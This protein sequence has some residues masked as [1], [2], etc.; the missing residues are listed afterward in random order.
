MSNLKRRYLLVGIGLGLLILIIAIALKSPPKQSTNQNKRT[1]V[2]VMTLEEQHVAPIITGYGRVAPKHVWQA[3]AEV[4]GRLIFRHPQLET[5]RLLP[6]GT[7]LLAID[8]LEY[9]L[10]LAQ[11][12]ANFNATQAKLTQL[13][14]QQQN[15]NTSLEIE[16]QRKVLSEQE[17]ARKKTLK[18]KNLVSS[19]EL[20]SQKL[21]LLAQ[22]KQVEELQNSLKLLPDDRKVTQAQLSVDQAKLEDAE[23]RLQKTEIVLPFDARIAEINI[24][25][26]QVVNMSAVMLTAYELGT[27]EIK[28]E[29]AIH[30]MRALANSLHQMP[31]NQRLPSIEKL[32]L[33]AEI[34]F[35]AGDEEF[36]W[37]AKVTRVAETVNPNN[38][39][40]GL[41]LEVE[42]DFH[43]IDLLRR[44]PLTKG[45]FVTAHIHGQPSKHLVVSEK[46]IHQNMLY[47]V[48]KDNRLKKHSLK[49]LFRTPKHV[50]IETN[51]T[52]GDRIV[53]N[54][55][56]PAIDG[57]AL[58][59][60]QAPD[61]NDSQQG[62]A[63]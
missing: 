35:E 48:T 6:Q 39:T 37:P 18:N 55:I 22:T 2:E 52:A 42:Q 30:D 29:V 53:V 7:R 17:Y 60:I 54:D 27:A 46:V 59:I 41:Y 57:M 9:Q 36:S 31:Q 23:R 25:Q 47:Q 4:S 62:G 58:S 61:S 33:T 15:L 19:S 3:V 20:E 50:A 16:L 28:A 24:E 44:P 34:R 38:A 45:M 12:Q 1:K 21:A 40:L 5:G 43:Q 49:V 10:Q 56:I 26:D 11:A 63:Q 51:L 8:P 32:E 13:D 14:Q